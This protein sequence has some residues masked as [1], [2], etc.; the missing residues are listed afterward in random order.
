MAEQSKTFCILPFIHSHASVS[1]HW[2]PCC[3]SFY[4]N[5]DKHYFDKEGYTHNSWFKSKRMDQLRKNLLNGIE[6]SMCDICWKSEKIS[7]E[8]LRTNYLELDRF[9]QF[10]NNDRFVK[11]PEIKYLDLKLS[12]EC[13]LKCRMCDYTN[14][15]KILEDIEAIEKDK[16]L[17]LPDNYQRSPNHEKYINNKGIKQMPDHVFDELV[18]DILPNL[19]LL[20]VTGGEPLVQKQVLDLFDI[21]IDKGYAKNINLN[22]TTNGTK[23]TTKFLEKLKNFKEVKFNISCD[24]Y[25]TVYDY[26]RHPFNWNKFVER[27]NDIVESKILFSIVTVPQMYNIENVSKLQKWN[28]DMQPINDNAVF[29]NT[30]LRPESNYNSLKYVPVY[31]LENTLENIIENN[32]SIVL[33]NYLKKLIG[34]KYQP[35]DHEYKNIVNSVKSLDIVREQSFKDYL[36]PM[37]TEWLEG[38]FKKYA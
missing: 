28:D 7:G 38:L 8:S 3:N 27:I 11:N 16:T 23:F 32:N 4:V 15:H 31:I 9:A 30:F 10:Q 22:I 5:T 29:L 24:G 21:C 20:K 19:E 34:Q 13:N 12:N 6:D 1:G 33:I 36:E 18:N 25:G 26:I 37:T 35:T 2:K 17:T 14:S